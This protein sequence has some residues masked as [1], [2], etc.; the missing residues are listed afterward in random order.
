M[1][2]V[3]FVKRLARQISDAGRAA[4]EK[5]TNDIMS[6]CSATFERCHATFSQNK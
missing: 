3:D 2:L 1:I 6:L 5:I 4:L